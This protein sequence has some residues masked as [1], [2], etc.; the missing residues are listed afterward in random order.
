[1]NIDRNGTSKEFN[2]EA[3]RKVTRIIDSVIYLMRLINEH[4]AR[5]CRN[6]ESLPEE[7]TIWGTAEI[8]NEAMDS[9]ATSVNL[10]VKNTFQ[11][12]MW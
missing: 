4:I 12:V 5:L 10:I 11:Q 8:M 1:M 6:L 2:A 7:F 9:A 3:L